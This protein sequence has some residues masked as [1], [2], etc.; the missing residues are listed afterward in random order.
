M[1]PLIEHIEYL[2]E[3]LR[4]QEN[5]MG[6]SLKLLSHTH[7]AIPTAA[8]QYFLVLD[9]LISLTGLMYRGRSL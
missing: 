5:H 3:F 4:G 1:F 7:T 9:L 8:I 6:G 2:G